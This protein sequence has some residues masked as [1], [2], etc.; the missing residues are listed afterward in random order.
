MF[1]TP[2][3]SSLSPKFERASTQVLTHELDDFSG[4]QSKLTA[5]GVERR[6]I[7]PCHLNNSIQIGI[8]K[9][10]THTFAGHGCR[11]HFGR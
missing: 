2:T 9:H 3:C 8:C 11:S 10:L 5:D 4:G 6:T 7:L 1:R